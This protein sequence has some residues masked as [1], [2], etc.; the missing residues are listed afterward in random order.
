MTAAV[1]IFGCSEYLLVIGIFGILKNSGLTTSIRVT[2]MQ[3]VFIPDLIL[4]FNNSIFGSE[5][6][7]SKFFAQ[8]PEDFIQIF[9]FV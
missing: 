3:I 6:F 5:N 1:S 4:P 8:I 9:V 2:T 7:F